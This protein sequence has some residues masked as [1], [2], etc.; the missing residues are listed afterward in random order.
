VTLELC[1]LRWGSDS[2]LAHEFPPGKRSIYAV[3]ADH[4]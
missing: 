3:G 1:V 2:A 4:W